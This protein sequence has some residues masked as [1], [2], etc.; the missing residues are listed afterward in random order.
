MKMY[1]KTGITWNYFFFVGR[2]VGVGKWEW[3]IVISM[4]VNFVL[5]G[6]VGSYKMHFVSVKP[7]IY[8]DILS[9]ITP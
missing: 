9:S 5:W 1:I 4:I 2:G 7:K 3:Y 6:P 8:C